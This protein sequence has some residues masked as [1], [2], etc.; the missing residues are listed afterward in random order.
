MN[1]TDR[2]FMEMSIKAARDAG[3]GPNDPLVG[4][5]AALN[6]ELQG[7]AAREEKDHAEF[8]L[9]EKRLRDTPL[10]G[11]TI[12]TTLE[13][14]IERGE[15]KTPCVERLLSRKVGKVFIGMLDPNPIVR[16]VGCT[17]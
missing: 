17:R 12:Y 11:A 9:L 1:P 16:G 10:A 2:Q 13:P 5:V 7:V 3:G 15:T 6:G 14:C 4:A 8:V